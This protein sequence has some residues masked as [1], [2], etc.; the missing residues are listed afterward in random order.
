MDR[1][2]ARSRAGIFS[3]KPAGDHRRHTNENIGVGGNLRWRE[4]RHTEMLPPDTTRILIDKKA[5]SLAASGQ[6]SPSDSGAEDPKPRGAFIKAL[7]L[8][9]H[10]L[11]PI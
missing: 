5:H 3:S 8:T 9:P 6:P 11:Q 2:E 1:M 7:G 10:T 4:N